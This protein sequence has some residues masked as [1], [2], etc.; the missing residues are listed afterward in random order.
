MFLDLWTS[1]STTN[2]SSRAIG[3]G[4]ISNKARSG[5]GCL[6]GIFVC[7]LESY[8]LIFYTSLPKGVVNPLVCS[9]CCLCQVVYMASGLAGGLGTG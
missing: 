8:L 4:G 5:E 6:G 3:C 1:P 9:L 2:V 7:E